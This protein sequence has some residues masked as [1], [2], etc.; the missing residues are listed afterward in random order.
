M[1]DFLAIIPAI[2]YCESVSSSLGIQPFNVFSNLFYLISALGLFLFWKV[3]GRQRLLI[4][5]LISLLI[6]VFS[7]VYHIYLT[8]ETL[9]FDVLGIAAFISFT[10]TLIA[11]RMLGF[12]NVAAIF[13]TLSLLVLSGLFSKFL[14]VP[15]NKGVSAFF[16][17][18]F[19]LVGLCFY[20]YGRSERLYKRFLEI[21]FIM[22]G[23]IIFKA[24]DILPVVCETMPMG[25]HAI[26]HGLT[27][28]V[29]V[30][31]S[32]MTYMRKSSN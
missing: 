12:S 24:I 31:L 2:N 16:P 15:F 18:L 4:A 17:S 7:T 29:L 32:T 3:D 27:A 30:R 22:L 5:S 8:K 21:S 13:A 6:A 28:M 11:S 25:T 1:V 23:A 9:L 10:M 20:F 19:V 26:W 14:E